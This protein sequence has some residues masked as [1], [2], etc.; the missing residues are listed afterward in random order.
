M[1]TETKMFY[2]LKFS[3]W[4]KISDIE[5]LQENPYTEAALVEWL[6]DI[7]L[8]L[9]KQKL[10]F[11]LQTIEKSIERNVFMEELNELITEFNSRS[12]ITPTEKKVIL[13]RLHEWLSIMDD[14]ENE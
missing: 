1:K 10:E 7:I 8:Y 11:A 13:S 12:N 5:A 4:P 14:I 6:T 3:D 2:A 9:S